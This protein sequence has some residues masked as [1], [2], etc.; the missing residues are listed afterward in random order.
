MKTLIEFKF[1][2]WLWTQW[3]IFAVALNHDIVSVACIV[4]F[5]VQTFMEK[6]YRAA[7]TASTDAKN[8]ETQELK[9]KIQELRT[10]LNAVNLTLGLRGKNGQKGL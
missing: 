9:D 5:L 1:P 3:A 10:E 6:H 4:A 8:Q 7:D 2:A